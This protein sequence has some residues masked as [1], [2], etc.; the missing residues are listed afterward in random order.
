MFAIDWGQWLTYF[1][2]AVALGADAFSLGIGM[3]LTGLRLRQIL[4]ISVVIGI[5]HVF[6][7]LIGILIGGML[8]AYVGDVAVFIGGVILIILGVHML[9]ESFFESESQTIHPAGGGL[10]LFAFGVSL[11]AFSVGLS[12]G[13]FAGDLFF[14]VIMFGIMGM[15]MSGSGLLLGRT[16]GQWLGRYGGLFGGTILLAFGIKFIM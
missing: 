2:I 12:L 5:F 3:G 7:P 15:M 1:L 10:I 9:W 14:A 13:L 8:T 4:K 16:M 6:M 11:D